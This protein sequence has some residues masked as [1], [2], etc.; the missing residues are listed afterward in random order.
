[1]EPIRAAWYIQAWRSLKEID[2]QNRALLRLEPPGYV[3]TE[4]DIAR[5]EGAAKEA[6]IARTCDFLRPNG[7]PIGRPGSSTRT[8]LM[9]GGLSAAQRDYDYLS[10]GGTAAPFDDGSMVRLP[11]EAGTVTLRPVTST[12]GSPAIDV[13]VPGVVRRKLH[14]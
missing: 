13:N 1:M 4:A 2:P 11:G 14:Y 9:F 7:Q 12:P 5:I 6:A 8:R 10:A 3:A